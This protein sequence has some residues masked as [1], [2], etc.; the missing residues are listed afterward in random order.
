M[1]MNEQLKGLYQQHWDKTRDE[2][3]IGKD[4]AFP[5]MISVSKR[6]ENATKKGRRGIFPWMPPALA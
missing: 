4:S 3:V 5:F 2:I 6:Y 1:S